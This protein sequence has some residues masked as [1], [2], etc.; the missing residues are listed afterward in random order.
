MKRTLLV[1]ATLSVLV[2][3]CQRNPVLRLEPKAHGYDFVDENGFVLATAETLADIC[4]ELNSPI[5]KS[6]LTGEIFLE[7]THVSRRHKGFQ[8]PDGITCDEIT[9]TFASELNKHGIT[10]FTSDYDNW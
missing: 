4:K 2:A 6:K 5:V 10:E 9:E 1:V 7:F 3:G 8:V